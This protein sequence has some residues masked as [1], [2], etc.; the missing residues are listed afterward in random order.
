MD[1]KLNMTP[2]VEE[3]I[4][5]TKKK[6]ESIVNDPEKTAKAANL[7]YVSDT[8][9]GITRIKVGEKFQY[10][11]GEKKLMMMKSCCG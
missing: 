7:V 8:E 5:L 1:N 4:K 9:P 2:T 11:F 3:T 6:I 10:Y